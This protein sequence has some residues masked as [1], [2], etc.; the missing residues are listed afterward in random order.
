[1][2]TICSVA[3]SLSLLLLAGF[4]T[5]E[6]PVHEEGA[7]WQPIEKAWEAS[8]RTGRPLL[9]FV[10]TDSCGFCHTMARRTYREPAV[11]NLIASR[12]IPTR[13]DVSEHPV[14][15]KKLG[16]RSF[17]TTVLVSSEARVIDVIEGYVAADK[18]PQRLL[19]AMNR[20]GQRR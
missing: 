15:S 9:I 18:F 10:T 14:L 11:A 7:D 1:M 16:V 8:K 4:A 12:F 13:F 17:P 5:A 3:A 6:S 19:L 2:R 20:Q